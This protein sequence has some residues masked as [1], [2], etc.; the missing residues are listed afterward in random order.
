M[1]YSMIATATTT[2]ATLH[3]AT[4]AATWHQ[5]NFQPVTSVGG[6]FATAPNEVYVAYS[7]NGS[8]P[9]VFTSKDSGATWNSDLG[10]VLNTDV[11]RD[12]AGNEVISSIGGI[13]IAHDNGAITKLDSKDITFSQN[14]ETFGEGLFGVTGSHYPQG[15]VGPVVNGVAVTTDGGSTF[16]YFDTGLYWSTY[17]A[18]YSAFPTT[19][20]WYVAQGSWSSSSTNM[21]NPSSSNATKVW[22]YTSKI[23]QE[24]GQPGLSVDHKVKENV[25]Y[26]AISKTTDGGK[27]FKEVYNTM[28]K[29]YMNEIDC[30]TPEICMAVA[31]DS[32]N[33]IVIR[34]E[35]GGKTWEEKLSLSDPKM[36][37]LVGC[38]MLS[39]SEAWVS[40]GTFDQGLVGW[41]YHT[42]DSGA[43]WELQTLPQGFSMDLSFS[44]GV[45]YSPAMSEFH[46]TVAIFN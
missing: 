17:V 30:S 9:G 2:V 6:V 15:V 25:H 43:T 14:V 46:S 44:G 27:T 34:T 24:V 29:Y 28:G 18:R 40:G 10:G 16:E 7:D 38:K 21:R 13:F 32:Y 35:N 33:A 37:S 41:Y 22:E 12:S 45:G 39:D 11:A 31:E 36:A 23:H 19:E 3:S 8:G 20:T 4:A 42:V 1:K 26:G 5:T